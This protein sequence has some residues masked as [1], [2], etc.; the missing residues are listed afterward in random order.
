M[1]A[2]AEGTLDL[3]GSQ[4]FRKSPSSPDPNNPRYPPPDPW[5]A[6]D[7]GGDPNIATLGRKKQLVRRYFDAYARTTG[8][9]RDQLATA[10]DE[11]LR[12]AGHSDGIVHFG[13]LEI[14]RVDANAPIK[15]CGQCRRPHLDPEAKVLCPVCI[16]DAGGRGQDCRRPPRRSLLRPI[17]GLTKRR[18]ASS[19]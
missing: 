4:L 11:L 14:Q 2:I 10:V 7:M 13:V 15:R 16:R 5:S 3:L 12:L 17:D 8:C 6:S 19:L 1:R 9:P 18:Q